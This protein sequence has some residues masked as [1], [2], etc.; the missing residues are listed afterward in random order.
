MHCGMCPPT[1]THD[2]PTLYTHG[3]YTYIHT[4]KETQESFNENE[5]KQPG[6]KVQMERKAC[7]GLKGCLKVVGRQQRLL[8][9]G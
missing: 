1:V 8:K 7:L 4:E 9:K 5:L 6:K 2:V 3:I